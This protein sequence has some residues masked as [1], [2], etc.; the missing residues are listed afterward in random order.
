MA[1]FSKGSTYNSNA[2]FQSIKFGADAPL[3]ETELNELQDIQTEA[4]AD[5]VR[6]SIYSGFTVTGYTST[7]YMSIPV[8]NIQTS[9]DSTAYVNGYKIVIPSGTK[10]ALDPPPTT[11]SRDDLVFLEVW[12]EEIDSTETIYSKGQAGGTTITNYLQDS[13]VGSETSKRVQLKWRLR[14]VAGV[15]FNTYTDD[16]MAKTNTRGT[17]Y[18]QGANASPLTSGNLYTFARC[19]GWV[20]SYPLDYGLY[21]AGDYTDIASSKATLGTADGFVYAIPMY[22]VRRRNSN[23]YL[24]VEN[25]NGAYNYNTQSII[26][27]T[28]Y[29]TTVPVFTM[30]S[31]NVSTGYNLIQ[32][33][34]IYR[35]DGTQKYMIKIM[36]KDGNNN[37]SIVPLGVYGITN[38]TNLTW[39]LVN[40]P[41][42]NYANVIDENDLIDLRHTVSF[43]GFDLER[44]AIDNFDKLTRGELTTSSRSD[45]VR[46]YH[47]LPK[48]PIDSNTIF[49]ASFDGTTTAEIGGAP[50]LLQSCGFMPSPTGAGLYNYGSN[51]VM[52]NIPNFY[53]PTFTIDMTICY[54]PPS[55]PTVKRFW[56]L[57]KKDDSASTG[58]VCDAISYQGNLQFRI[59]DGNSVCVANCS[60]KQ[61]TILAQNLKGALHFRFAKN[62]TTAY[63]YMNGNLMVST[64][65][66][67]TMFSNTNLDIDI[68]GLY[69][70]TGQW[71]SSVISDFS[72]SK[73][74]RGS[75]FET[76]PYDVI[77]GYGRIG[78]G[79][80]AQKK[81]M[82]DALTVET[83]SAFIGNVRPTS[84]GIT[85]TGLKTNIANG[86]TLKVK[87]LM[88]DVITGLVD[89]DTAMARVVSQTIT[90]LATFNI[91]LD[92]VTAFAVNDTITI[93]NNNGFPRGFGTVTVN[94][95]DTT[96]KFITVTVQNI[97]T[98]PIDIGNFIVEGTVS[99][100]AP[101]VRYYSAGTWTSI[102]GTWSNLGTTEATFTC[103]E[104]NPISLTD[105]EIQIDYALVSQTGQGTMAE[106]YQNCVGGEFTVRRYDDSFASTGVEDFSTKIAGT[107][108]PCPHI[109]LDNTGHPSNTGAIENP[110]TSTLLTEITNYSAIASD[111]GTNLV[112]TSTGTNDKAQQVFGFD[113]LSWIERNWGAIPYS[114]TQ[115]KIAW[116]KSVISNLEFRYKGYGY[117]ATA[118]YGF[119]Q[120]IWN[121]TTS[122]W[123]SSPTYNNTTASSYASVTS[124]I[125]PYLCDNGFV[126]YMLNAPARGTSD[127]ASTLYTDYVCLIINY[128]PSLGSYNVYPIDSPYTEETRRLIP[129]VVSVT[130]DFKDKLSG[131]AGAGYNPNTAKAQYATSMIA[132]SGGGW[133]E[134]SSTSYNNI[135]VD[136]GTVVSQSTS[137]SG[138]IPQSLF[139]FNIIRIIEDK[140]GSI[141]ASNKVGWIKSNIDE[142]RFYAK[143]T[144]SFNGAN[145]FN[146]A[147]WRADTSAWLYQ[148]QNTSSTSNIIS[149]STLSLSSTPAT[150]MG[151]LIDSNGFANWSLYGVA[152]NGTA[153]SVSIDYAKIEIK[154]KRPVGYSTLNP[155]NPR[156]DAGKGM[157][158]FMRYGLKEIYSY[159]DIN[160]RDKL[161]TFGNYIPYQGMDSLPAYYYA[162]YRHPFAYV[163]TRGTAGVLP[164]SLTPVTPNLPMPWSLRD[165]RMDSGTL[166]Y[167]QYG[168]NKTPLYSVTG[169]D[170]KNIGVRL[171]PILAGYNGR[172][173]N[174]SN[175]ALSHYSSQGYRGWTINNYAFMAIPDMACNDNY[176]A[177]FMY[178]GVINGELLLFVVANRG[179]STAGFYADNA[180]YA[181]SVYKIVGRPLTKVGAYI[182]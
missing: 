53:T 62:A 172:L 109:A 122:A 155:E 156:R 26:T 36:S 151:I 83:I 4:R 168:T 93:C 16:G 75:N 100:S 76:L 33:G 111:N 74:D 176:L 102:A 66:S 180:N 24:S 165:Y 120:R 37:C 110:L 63:L 128:S 27:N 119:T 70:N 126:Y 23:G 127:G 38:C 52:Y 73:V 3:L 106:V 71:T 14:A 9:G 18:A 179:N 69:P 50:K 46:T 72:I 105:K 104:T 92:T 150:A 125:T 145:Q 182:L 34:E 56:V 117:Q 82:S 45:I 67:G 49:Y 178:M 162:I 78:L 148:T 7:S 15:D 55:S 42:Y 13:R 58:L 39:Y 59:F 30:A 79:F 2:N 86:D 68:D 138:Q 154:L 80:N 171:V 136:D 132:P 99:S 31:I 107:M 90:S 112:T 32:E 95:I 140:F 48:T 147:V 160:S 131:I 114:T 124:S 133:T 161:S 173:T 167:K 57:R 116:I 118:G 121:N 17:I 164:D 149:A 85:K 47:G 20:T 84:A 61:E 159:F 22:R 135:G 141:P 51:G 175:E 44:L 129:S 157:C 177:Y 113:L 41:D 35:C 174:Y 115:E 144:G 21:V 54:Y 88:G 163:T 130:D 158:I 142:I 65:I 19:T 6:E 134:Y 40:R 10:V 8:N 96:N 81:I 97:P 137:T 91:Y 153:S 169:A 143:G 12:K 28:T 152:S 101:L 98:T 77:A 60:L 29:A 108:Q 87:G 166:T 11:G 1:D 181:G 123:E 5:I 43:N 170:S 25:P 64:P 94:A 103:T 89:S 146:L 139:T